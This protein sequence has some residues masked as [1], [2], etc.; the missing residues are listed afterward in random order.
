MLTL[1]GGRLQ[2]NHPPASGTGSAVRPRAPDHLINKALSWE[3]AQAPE[4]FKIFL[5]VP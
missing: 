4:E 3:D 5:I 2:A 1:K